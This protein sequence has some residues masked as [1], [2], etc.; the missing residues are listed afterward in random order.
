DCV[1]PHPGRNKNERGHQYW[2]RDTGRAHW[3]RWIGRA[4]PERPEPERSCNDPARRDPRRSPRASR[5][6]EFRFARSPLD[7]E[8]TA[9]VGALMAIAS[10]NPTTGET[11]QEF[12]ALDSAQIETKLAK[13]ERAFQSYR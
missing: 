11:E 3:R 10:T 1:A 13:S 8:G 6:M 12:D 2:N 7:S 5:P 4:N 9:I